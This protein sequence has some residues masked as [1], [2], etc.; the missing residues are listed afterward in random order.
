VPGEDLRAVMRRF[1][2]GV[3][4]VT[5]DADGQ[6]VGL[7]V[8]SLVAL[9]LEPPLVGVAVAKQ[10]ALHELLREAGAFAVSLLAGGQ[11]D[12]AQHFARGVPPIAMWSGVEVEPCEGAPLVSGAVG[13]LRCALRSETDAATHTFFAGAVEEARRGVDAPPLLRLEGGYRPA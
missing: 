2:S 12:V 5:V 11:E 8:G 4:V 10:A 9:S 6:R 3:A 1:P 13:W 7:T